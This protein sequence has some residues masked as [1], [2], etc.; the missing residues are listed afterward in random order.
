[1]T[2]L[3]AYLNEPDSFGKSWRGTFAQQTP[4]KLAVLGRKKELPKL[5][6]KESSCYFHSSWKQYA[7]RPDT[8]VVKNTIY[9]AAVVIDRRVFCVDS[10]PERVYVS[11]PGQSSMA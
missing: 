5:M 9:Y 8:G 11:K 1:M 6:T 4:E 3:H 10:V 2:F 7:A